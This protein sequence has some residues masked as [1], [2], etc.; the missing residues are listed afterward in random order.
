[1]V[2]HFR[3]EKGDWIVF[4]TKKYERLLAKT[5]NKDFAWKQSHTHL[6]SEKQAKI[7]KKNINRGRFPKTRKLRLL[8]SYVRI[9][10]E[11]DLRDKIEALIITRKNKK[12]QKFKRNAYV[13]HR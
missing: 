11:C 13:A 4:N 12:K 2:K 8:Y 3:S 7:M 1:M 6:I 9:M 5:R 10:E